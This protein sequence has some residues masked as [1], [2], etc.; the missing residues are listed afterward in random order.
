MGETG[1][2]A[3]RRHRAARRRGLRRAL[4]LL[5]AAGA[6]L[7][8]AGEASSAFGGGAGSTLGIPPPLA[9]ITQLGTAP[10]GVVAPI[11]AV[12]THPGLDAS[13]KAGVNAVRS[14]AGLRALR[15]SPKL[16]ASSRHHS[17]EMIVAG[18]FAHRSAD[19]SPF[20]RRIAR[21]YRRETARTWSVGEN[22][23]WASPALTHDEVVEAWLRS[24]PHR[25]NLLSPTWQE[26]GLS[27]IAV[28]WA[29]GVFSY[30]P[31][32][33]VTMDFGTRR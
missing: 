5:P 4:A 16:A 27:T 10:S 29:P 26:V 25:A 30:L 9:S 15:F 22:I 12:S 18:Y 32:T 31:V 1:S 2:A 11:S 7:L 24:P 14:R 19:G 33:V 23:A 3:R 17:L 13:I 6:G 20:W 8:I 21:F 28:Q